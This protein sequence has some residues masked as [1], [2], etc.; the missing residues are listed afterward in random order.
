MACR[1]EI[2]VKRG[3]HHQSRSLF[4]KTLK[5]LFFD[6]MENLKIAGWSVLSYKESMLR[7]KS[8]PTQNNMIFVSR[9]RDN[10]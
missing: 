5:I 3:R 10:W 8:K 7:N 4:W 1:K 6:G 9:P 2:W